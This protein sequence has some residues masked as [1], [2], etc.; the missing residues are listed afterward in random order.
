MIQYLIPG[1]KGGPGPVEMTPRARRDDTQKK[2]KELKK[3]KNRYDRENKKRKIKEEI[4][5]KI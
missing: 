4:H 1:V 5:Y 3:R 2:L